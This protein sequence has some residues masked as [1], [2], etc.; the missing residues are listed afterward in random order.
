MW[1]DDS[2]HFL[3]QDAYEEDP[4]HKGRNRWHNDGYEQHRTTKEEIDEIVRNLN[5]SA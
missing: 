3:Y 5:Y 4:L 1:V 2:P